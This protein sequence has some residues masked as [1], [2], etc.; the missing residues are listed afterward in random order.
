MRK[1]GEETNT[2][3]T[4]QLCWIANNPYFLFSTDLHGNARVLSL[5][6]DFRK[7]DT[8]DTVP[9]LTPCLPRPRVAS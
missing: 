8:H 5:H 6:D 2:A 9:Y 1:K 3:L 4:V 7:R